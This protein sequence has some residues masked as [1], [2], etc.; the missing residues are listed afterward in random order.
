MIEVRCLGHI[1][2]SVGSKEV[3]LE[4]PEL[5]PSE[6]IERLR[7]ISGKDDPGFTKFN[8]LVMVEEGEAF[9][10]A[11]PERRVKDGQRVALI[12]FSHGG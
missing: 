2:S 4:G 12:P 7:R 3:S 1:G 10:A 6:I 5:S 8:T 11:A 9:L